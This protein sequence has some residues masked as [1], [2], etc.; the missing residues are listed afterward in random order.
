LDLRLDPETKWQALGKSPSSAWVLLI[1]SYILAKSLTTSPASGNFGTPIT[2]ALLGAK[3]SLTIVT[4]PESTTRH[5]AGIPVIRTPYTLPDLTKAF[6]GHDAVV[7][8]VGPGGIKHQIDFIDAAEAAGVYRFIIDDFGWGPD[9]RGFPEF[10]AIHAHRRL[11][12]DHARARAEA[13]P[14]FTWTGLSTGNPIDWVRAIVERK[15]VV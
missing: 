12:W 2:E 13:N 1:K 9:V 3:L 4:R 15:L 10:A 6:S 5:P 7:C 11:G 14:H 8:V